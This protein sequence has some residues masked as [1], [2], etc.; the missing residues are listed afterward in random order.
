M[1]A[2]MASSKAKPAMV[3]TLRMA[4]V[5]SFSTIISQSSSPMVGM[6]SRAAKK[7]SFVSKEN[8]PLRCLAFFLFWPGSLDAIFLHPPVECAAAQAEGVCRLAHVPSGTR[9]GFADEDTLNGFQAH[10]FESLG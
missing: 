1:K 9:Q 5:D 4:A 10:L 2:A 6:E 7:R 8:R 3:S